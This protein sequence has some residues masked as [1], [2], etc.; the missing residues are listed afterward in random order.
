MALFG[1]LQLVFMKTQNWSFSLWIIWIWFSTWFLTRDDFA[2]QGTLAL[3]VNICAYRNWGM[4]PASSRWRPGKLRNILRCT[5]QPPQQ[6]IVWS[7]RSITSIKKFWSCLKCMFYSLLHERKYNM[8]GKDQLENPKD[9]T[10]NLVVSST[11]LC[12]LRELARCSSMKWRRQISV[13]GFILRA[14]WVHRCAVSAR[15]NPSVNNCWKYGESRRIRTRLCWDRLPKKYFFNFLIAFSPSRNRNLRNHVKHTFL[16]ANFSLMVFTLTR[17]WSTQCTCSKGFNWSNWSN[18]ILQSDNLLRIRVRRS[19]I[20]I[21]EDNKNKCLKLRPINAIARKHFQ[22]V[23]NVK[24]KN[25]Q[26]LDLGC[27]KQN[28]K[29]LKRSPLLMKN[30]LNIKKSPLGYTTN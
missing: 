20:W 3:S 5:G 1:K 4:T 27:T 18:H 8:V 17:P 7:N 22:G 19:Q 24:K 11:Q 15:R 12:G 9:L 25:K 29:H 23:I 13:C 28:K 16:R 6:Q 30:H 26:P 2:P 10:L 14:A 21:Y